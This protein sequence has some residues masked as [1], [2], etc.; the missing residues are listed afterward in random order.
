M[1]PFPP[2]L[3]AEDLQLLEPQPEVVLEP[4]PEV[5]LIPLHL[6]EAPPN[7]FWDWL[8]YKVEVRICRKRIAYLPLNLCHHLLLKVV[9][10]QMDVVWIW[11]IAPLNYLLK[12]DGL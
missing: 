8:R 1:L 12:K 7:P 3:N 6:L 9:E 10:L 4:Q 5:V 2:R 11:S